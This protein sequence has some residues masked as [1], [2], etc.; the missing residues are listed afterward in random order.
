ML[1]ATI[2]EMQESSRE[3][4]LDATWTLPLE[5]IPLGVDTDLHRPA[6]A[7]QRHDARRQL[8]IPD[9]EYAL[10]FV[11]RLSHHAKAH[12]HPFFRSAQVA[13][14]ALPKKIHIILCGWFANEETMS[15][16]F[17][18]ARQVAPSVRIHYVD[19]VNSAWRYTAHHAADVFVSLSDN[20]QETFGLAP[21]E[22]MSAGLPVILSDWNGYRDLVDDGLSGFLIPTCMVPR[23]ADAFGKRHASDEFNYDYFL[24][25]VNQTVSV[26]TNV[27]AQRIITLLSNAQLRKKMGERARHRAYDVFDWR[28][29]VA[30][31]EAL[32]NEQALLL[33]SHLKQGATIRRTPQS[34][35]TSPTFYPS[36]DRAFA[37]YPTEFL[38]DQTMLDI[39]ND[40]STK[41]QQK[42]NDRL[43][44]YCLDWSMQAE[45]VLTAFREVSDAMTLS[46]LA[47]TLHEQ[48]FSETHSRQI[49]AW[50]LKYDLITRQVRELEHHSAPE[51]IDV[52]SFDDASPVQSNQALVTF[53]VTCK[54][55]LND[56]QQSL[57]RV[58]KQPR[59]KLI[60]VDY[61]CPQKAGDWV[62]KNLPSA[63]VIRVNDRPEFLRSEAKN[64]GGFAAQTP[65]I[66]FMDADIILS[67]DFVERIAGSLRPNR[68][69]RNQA[70]SEGTGGTFVCPSEVF[71][72]CGGH[73]PV[74][75]GWGEEDDDLLD[76]LRF[77]GCEQYFFPSHLVSHLEHEDD[78]R[79]EYHVIKDRSTSHMINRVYRALKWDLVR[80]QNAMPSLRKRE[81][82]YASAASAVTQ[83]RQ[84]GR[85]IVEFDLGQM[86]WKPISMNCS[87]RLVYRLESTMEPAEC[88]Q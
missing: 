85:A 50:L 24:G 23:A 11:G 81:Q 75:R 73:D 26:A 49:I 67:A 10:L 29:I 22:A 60:V 9:D 25:K 51:L 41:F 16:F 7:K 77:F 79:M 39:T 27:C 3:Q 42:I 20:I 17:E 44:N 4:G 83:C 47:H 2:E 87:R 38:S 37:G 84:D 76:A 1:T 72:Q 30:L 31:Y 88:K 65:Y 53:V 86:L 8:G 13:S 34:S 68:L 58:I 14:E 40:F 32:W 71:R 12:P 80:L 52:S 69:L 56:L 62:A 18:C 45:K 74:Y 54:G 46:D 78:R 55:R 15:A 59:S 5:V 33:A 66:C 43:C 48:G 57:A 19:G 61:D 36:I 35:T 28:K 64:F 6:N 82:W 21:I 70:I 63:Q